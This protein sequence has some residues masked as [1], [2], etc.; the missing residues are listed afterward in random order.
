MT[1][2]FGFKPQPLSAVA[3][4]LAFATGSLLLGCDDK[5]SGGGSPDIV[6]TPSSVSFGMCSGGR[7]VVGI[8][9]CNP[10]IDAGPPPDA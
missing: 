5:F 1:N 6:A 4:A 8:S 2:W 3:L 7:W 10:P 9:S